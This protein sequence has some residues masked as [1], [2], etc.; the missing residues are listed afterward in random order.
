MT[1][2]KAGWIIVGSTPSSDGTTK[3]KGDGCLLVFDAE[4]RHVAT[5]AGPTINGPWGNMAS[6]DRGDSATCSSA[7]PA[8]TF[9]APR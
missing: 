8:S 5:W 7:W 4:G 9:P 1:M 3:T 6:I 2:L